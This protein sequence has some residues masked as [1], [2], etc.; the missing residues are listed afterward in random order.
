VPN[1]QNWL[2]TKE[3]IQYFFIHL[4]VKKGYNLIQLKR[5]LKSNLKIILCYKGLIW[6]GWLIH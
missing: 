4:T 1:K 5:I 6:S 3:L 2:I